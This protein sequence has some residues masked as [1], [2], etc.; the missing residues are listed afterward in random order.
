VQVPAKRGGALP[1]PSA[2]VA[3]LLRRSGFGG[4]HVADIATLSALDL[5]AVVDHVLDMSAAPADPPPPE[6]S[7]PN[8]GDW[9][10][11]WAMTKWWLDRMATSPTPLQ[12]KMALFW[13]G[14]FVSSE[15]KVNDAQMMYDQNHLFRTEG[16]GSFETL[17]HDMALQ[18]AMLRYLDNDPN[19][20]GNPNENFARELME[21]F[22]LGVNQYTQADVAASARAWTGHNLDDNTGQYHFYPQYHDYGPETFMG[23]SQSWDGPDIIHFILT[24]EPHRSTAARYMANK[25]WSFFAYLNPDPALLDALQTAFVNSNLDV[26]TLLRTIFNRPEFYSTQAKRGLVKSPA[27][28]VVAALRATSLSAQVAQPWNMDQMG[29]QFFYPPNVAGWKQNAYWIATTATWARMDYASNNIAWRARD[30]GFLSQIA[31]RDAQNNYLMTPAQAVQAAFDAFGIDAPSAATRAMLESWLTQ[32]RALPNVWRNY[33][34]ENL[35][36]LMMLAPEFALS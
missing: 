8:Q 9:E 6:F 19:V 21:L 24:V 35:T 11:V 33:Q 15:D 23:V 14:H 3:H 16:L 32:Q 18:P 1:T 30:A 36:I 13:H 2:D 28:F 26:A 5:P 17:C 25:L 4:P 7:D 12:E 27:E 29:Q 22:T 10:R 34:F 20:K 31:A